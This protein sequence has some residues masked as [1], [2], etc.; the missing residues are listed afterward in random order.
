MVQNLKDKLK[1]YSSWIALGAIGL[2]AMVSPFAVNSL[3]D[4][5]AGGIGDEEQNI[6]VDLPGATWVTF[7]KFSGYHTKDDPNKVK[8]GDNPQ[9]QNTFMNNGDRIS[10]RDLGYEI[11]PSTDTASSSIS[12]IN[13]MHT[14]R[15]RSGENVL[16]RTHTTVVEWYDENQNVW[17]NLNSGY[18]SGYTFG[19]ADYNINTDQRSYTYFGNS[20]EAFSRWTGAHTNLSAALAGAEATINVD[21]TT[22]FDSSGTVRIC[23][24]NVTYTGKTGTS[25]T[26]AAGTPACADNRGVAQAV[27]TYADN[28]RGNIYLVANN[29]LFVSGV[30]S[31]TQAVFFSQY[32]DATDFLTQSLVTDGTAEDSGIFNL[33]EGGGGVTAM[34]QDE[35]AIYIFKRSIIYKA[36]LNDAL[37]T[38]QPL[39]PFDGKSQTTGAINQQSTFAGGN[40][41]FFI[42]PDNQIMNLTRVEEVDYPQIVPISDPIKPTTDV[43]N[44]A[45]STGIFWKNKAYISAKTTVDSSVNDVVFI[46]NFAINAWE[47]PVVGWNVQDWAIYDEAAGEG[48]ELFFGHANNPNSYKT[49]DVALDDIHGLAANWRSKQFDFG[50]LFPGAEMLLKEFDNVFVEGYISDNTSL[51]IS[52]LLDEDGVTQVYSTT[53]VGT[54]DDYI[55]NSEEYNVFG[56]E[57]FGIERFGTNDDFSTK[58][59]F[60]IYLNK[61]FRRVPFY[62]A[63]IEF[64]SDQEAA[65]WEVT[66]FGFLV[67]EHSQSE[68]RSLYRSFR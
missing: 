41:I 45:S 44:F 53:F 57:S 37:Y 33:A 64:A 30:V 67:R 5:P 19:F 7:D 31:T 27:Q 26:G 21:D 47:S 10:V 46:Y 40:G 42:T 12:S 34:V 15:R 20:Q 13:N 48:E 29:R 35:N 36:T 25:F 62:N 14:F 9:G 55:F 61:D 2:F 4:E 16:I 52:L 54:E 32:G 3:K 65:E 49:N 17:E 43:A 60:R 11:F 66:R 50:G 56:F 28:P 23:G 59:K 58:K 39:K 8:N 63:Q 22:G 68:D 51:T 38:L 6:G 24:T 1:Q 18:T